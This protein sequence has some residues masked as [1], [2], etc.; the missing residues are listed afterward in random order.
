MKR[1]EVSQ[2]IINDEELR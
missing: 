1:Q 2:L